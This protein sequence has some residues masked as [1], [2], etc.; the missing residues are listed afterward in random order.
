MK[1]TKK[2]KNKY[3][4]IANVVYWIA[5]FSIIG[6][7]LYTGKELYEYF[8]ETK[9][10]AKS[11]DIK[12]SEQEPYTLYLTS[13]DKADLIAYQKMSAKVYDKEEGDFTSEADSDSIKELE[14]EYNKLP[15]S[16]KQ[17]ESYTYT[18]IT[19]LWPIKSEYKTFFTNTGS[20]NSSTTPNE[21]KKF[22][23]KN[24]PVV[25]KYLDDNTTS[26]NVFLNQV[27]QNI[28]NLSNDIQVLGKIINVFDSTF[29]AS[30]KSIHVKKDVS[31][32]GLVDYN[33]LKDQLI[34]KWSVVND[35]LTPIVNKS[36]EI[37]RKHDA[38]IEKIEIY[39]RTKEN[40]NQF[41]TF[42]STYNNYKS[43]LIDIPKL[44]ERKDLEQY[45]DT[46]KFDIK[47]EYSDTIKKDEVI[48]Q[49]PN[50][51]DYKKFFKGSVMQVIISKG[52]KPEEPKEPKDKPKESL[53]TTSNSSSNTNSS[54][55]R[56]DVTEPSTG[57][58]NESGGTNGISETE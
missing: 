1:K 28:N 43:S 8:F 47:E 58:T 45:K 36:T 16:L 54:Q 4:Q 30:T 49:S 9:E 41:D 10:I 48:S 18:L 51:G 2:R 25:K 50:Q 40:K 21:M 57:E 29:S 6:T 11:S 5:V 27:Y 15:D 13:K 19:S 42:V 17:R 35:I 31:S 52:K 46:I 38:Q 33:T 14:K 44:T 24:G 53:T 39:T 55:T 26:K 12:I 32:Q 20:I 7:G 34:F 56:T 23:D 3:L 37:L 22:I